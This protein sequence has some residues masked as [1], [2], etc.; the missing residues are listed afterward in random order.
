MG[1][2]CRIEIR[3][4]CHCENTHLIH[5]D[6]YFTLAKKVVEKKVQIPALK[7]KKHSSEIVYK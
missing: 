7:T 6:K 1:F 4:V 2:L 5:N 3:P